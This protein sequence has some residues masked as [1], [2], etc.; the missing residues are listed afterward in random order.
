MRTN[1]VINDELMTRALKS[2]GCRTKRAAIETGLRLLIQVTSQ[3]KLRK[4][5]GKVAWEGDL[6]AMRRG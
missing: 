3:K 4:L 6:A 5:K 2:A 1:V